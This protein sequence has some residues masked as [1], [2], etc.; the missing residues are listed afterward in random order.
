MAVPLT[1]YLRGGEYEGLDVVPEEI[2]WCRKNITPN[3]PN[4]VFLS[5]YRGDFET[6]RASGGTRKP[7]GYT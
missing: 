3:I 7:G 5:R 2:E 4:S 1:G 6:G